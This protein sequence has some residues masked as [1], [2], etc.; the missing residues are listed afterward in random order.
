MKYFVMASVLVLAGCQSPPRVQAPLLLDT[1]PMIAVRHGGGVQDGACPMWVKVNGVMKGELE[2]GQSLNIDLEPGVYEVTLGRS[3]GGIFGAGTICVGSLQTAP[4]ITRSVQVA[5][6]PV[7]LVYDMEGTGKRW[8]PL[9]G[10]FLA[11]TPVLN[12]DD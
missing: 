5:N 4:L 9:A 12:S 2:N 7:R 6:R 3:R 10:L 8:I 1:K 11:P